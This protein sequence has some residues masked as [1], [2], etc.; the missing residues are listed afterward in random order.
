MAVFTVFAWGHLYNPKPAPQPAIADLGPM[1]SDH[2]VRLPQF[3]AQHAVEMD[4]AADILRHRKEAW[5]TI[6]GRCY[7]LTA[8]DICSTQLLG[9]DR[10]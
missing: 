7:M 8:P 4:R 1:E 6:K 5:E 10:S 9:Y 2:A 3:V